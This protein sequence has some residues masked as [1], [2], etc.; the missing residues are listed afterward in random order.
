MSLFLSTSN[1]FAQTN[2]LIETD[3]L[4]I[5]KTLEVLPE[6]HTY[7]INFN[8]PTQAQEEPVDVD[9]VFVMDTTAITNYSDV[10]AEINAFLDSVVQ[11][12][13]IRLN[14]G[15][16]KFALDINT[17]TTALTTLSDS[18]L[19]EVKAYFSPAY[20]AGSNMYGAILAGRNLLET[21]SAT[22]EYKYLIVASDFGG[23][24]SD[25]GDGKGLSF[26]YNYSYGNQGVEALHNNND[27]HGRYALYNT[28]ENATNFFTVDKVD[29]LINKKVFF[30]G[31]AVSSETDKYL[32]QTGSSVGEFPD[33]WRNPYAGYGIINHTW[34]SEEKAL[35]ISD[36]G[37][38]QRADFPTAFEK[39][40]YLSGNEFLELK[41]AGYNVIAVTSPYQPDDGSAYKRKFNA[42][43][44]AFKDWFES[45][46]GDRYEITEG[47]S[48]V[49]LL[50]DLES[51]LTYLL[52]KGEIVDVVDS[53]FEVLPD[54]AQITL[55]G[56]PLPKTTLDNGDV[57]FGTA[58]D[59]VYPYVYHYEKVDGKEVITW[60]I[61]KEA[62]KDDLLQFKFGIKLKEVPAAAGEY[63]YDTN[64]AADID[65]LSSKEVKDG[66]TE[67]TKTQPMPSPHVTITVGAVTAKY[68][69]E[70]GV[71][72]DPSVTTTGETGTDYSTTEKTIAGYTF[73]RVEGEPS[74]TYTD[75]KIIVTYVYKRVPVVITEGTVTAKY[76]DENGVELDPSVTTTGET[77]TDYT[78]T[79]K[80]IA[81]YTFVRVEGEP[82][83]T[84]TDGEIIVTYVYKKVPVEVEV[85]NKPKEPDNPTPPVEPEKSKL[86]DTGVGN[87]SIQISFFM[88][89][90][91]SVMLAIGNRKQKKM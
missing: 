54:T 55:N 20:Q 53:R 76:V 86:P 12:K 49:N 30:N 11:N 35:L 34:T 18:T 56:A 10:R 69:D 73:V 26:F 47:E 28:A 39:N 44:N 72:L 43:S 40:I 22:S 19:S 74:G 91:G 33:I 68:V 52:G 77:G 48:F 27:F 4:D 58:Q 65:Y 59:D 7:N 79:E 89:A 71:E 31:T 6:K 46:I 36:W 81:G 21:G 50:D 24:K 42:A 45:N 13:S 3:D 51:E 90:L 67:F 23:Y 38:T 16:I 80:T 17:T 66:I 87:E 2:E 82:S 62:R 75:G 85:P 29:D 32:T 70:N 57:A 78:T 15:V 88:I 5:S 84:Y 25:T 37:Y 9:V 60:S 83:G 14:V 63:I 41:D 8:L 1:V 61:H 64:E